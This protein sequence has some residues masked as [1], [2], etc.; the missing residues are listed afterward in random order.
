MAKLIWSYIII[1]NLYYENNS[2]EIIQSFFLNISWK[3]KTLESS[4]YFKILVNKLTNFKKVE[5]VLCVYFY[6]IMKSILSIWI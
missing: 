1:S 5:Q 4:T 6:Y 3:E 2:V